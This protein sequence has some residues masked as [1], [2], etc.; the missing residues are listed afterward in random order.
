MSETRENEIDRN[1]IA[2]KKVLDDILEEHCGEYALLKDRK[3]I[4]Y[5][6]NAGDAERAGAAKFPNGIYSVQ[7]VSRE[8]IDL[9]FYSHAFAQGEA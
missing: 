8:P 6:P 1:Y 3:V 2:F 4:S 9:G 5:H 7:L